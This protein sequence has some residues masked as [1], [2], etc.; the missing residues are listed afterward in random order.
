MPR[1]GALFLALVWTPLVW[2][3]PPDVKKGPFVVVA[4]VDQTADDTIQPRPTADVDAKAVYDLFKDPQYVGVPKDRLI[5]LTRTA[6]DARN[7]QVATRENVL[8]AVK[9]AVAETGKDDPVYLFFFGRGAS[10]GDATCIFT[11]DTVFKDRGKTGLLGTDLAV[12]LKK[13]KDQKL[14]VVL[15]VHFKG[16]DAGKEAI[17][18]PNLSD[19]LKGLFGTEEKGEEAPLPHDKLLLMSAIPGYDPVTKGPN[20][21]FTSVMLD[22]LRGKA[23]VEGYEPDGVVT[24]DE[25]TKYVEREAQNEARKLGTTTKEKESIPYIVGEET[26]HFVMTTN[27]AVRPAADTRVKA[28][29]E[30][31]TGLPADVISQ[32]TAILVRMPKLKAEQDLRKKAQAFADGKATKD[33]YLAARADILALMK[34]PAAAANAFAEKVL[35]A[36]GML[37]DEYVKKLNGGELIAA[38]VKGLYR[39]LELDVP[40]D[41][42][43]LISL[44]KGLSASKQRE[45]LVTAREKLGKREDLDG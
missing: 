12:E 34:L 24:V 10:S 31:T 8:N 40:A 20:G 15:D 41:L 29:T 16:F 11:T 6:D 36:S 19:I 25:F 14:C 35:K 2:A 5:L 39:R 21:A 4:G 9:R 44:G 42:N 45:L 38:S 22:A 7:G 28:F 30:K 13:A 43:S 37:Q 18:E 17:V 26:S 3:D 27:P 33:E 1:L 32:G 23:D